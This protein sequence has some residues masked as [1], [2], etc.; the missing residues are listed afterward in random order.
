MPQTT[1]S[2]D[3]GCTVDDLYE[4]S[5]KVEALAGAMPS[6]KRVTLLEESENRAVSRWEGQIGI[7][8]M[9]RALVWEEEDVWE[10]PQKTVRFRQIKGDLKVYEGWVRIAP[11]GNGARAEITVV[12][13][14]GIPFLTGLLV[15]VVDKIVRDNATHYLEALGKVA[16]ANRA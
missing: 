2:R 15:K 13:D 12:Y 14:L 8:G 1:I 3:F 9:T 6:I 11:S 4:A 10:A 5:R 7:A 16:M